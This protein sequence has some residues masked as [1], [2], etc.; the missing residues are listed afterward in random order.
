MGALSGLSAN[1]GNSAISGVISAALALPT[2]GLVGLWE[3][4]SLTTTG[5]QVDQINDKVGSN[6]IPRTAGS[7]QVV[8]GAVVCDGDDILLTSP[9][10]LAATTQTLIVIAK[11]TGSGADSVGFGRS[12]NKGPFSLGRTAGNKLA[13]FNVPP[14]TRLESSTT[15]SAS[16]FICGSLT[17]NG[18]QYEIFVNGVSSGVFVD[19]NNASDQT[20]TVGSAIRGS[21]PVAVEWKA[22]AVYQN[23]TQHAAAVAYFMDKY[24][25]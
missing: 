24:G 25:L 20:I 19:S 22:M 14:T 5:S 18:T 7:P 1:T 12:F 6:P 9:V 21:A 4:D 3:S 23:I 16:A 11:F 10:G 15:I 8:N 2:T 13:L 17:Y